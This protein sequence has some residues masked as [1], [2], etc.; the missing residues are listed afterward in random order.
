M[1]AEYSSVTGVCRNPPTGDKHSPALLSLDISDSCATRAAIHRIKPDVI[2]HAAAANPGCDDKDMW[3]VNYDATKSIAALANELDC[4]L[5]FIS[6]DIVHNGLN[7]PYADDA[8]AHPINEYGR[9]KA[10]GEQALPRT[11]SQAIV[12]RTSLIYGL[13]QIDRGTAGFLRTLKSQQNLRLFTDVLRQPVWIDALCNAI[14]LLAFEH[15]GQTG[16][17]NVAGKQI[18]SRADFALK[19]LR[20][21]GESDTSSVNFISGHGIPG[22]PLNCSLSLA[23]AES[24]GFNLP[25]VDDVLKNVP[26]RRSQK[27]LPDAIGAQD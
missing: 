24:L 26:Y 20:F 17:I 3:S 14:C 13:E 11:S 22:L 12:V 7:A 18:L 16:T 19:M 2:I 1:A 6:T 25:G 21:W 15:T 9:S 5:I 27:V 23:R 10:A 4:R 8:R